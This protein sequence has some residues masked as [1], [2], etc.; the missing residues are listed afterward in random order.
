MDYEVEGDLHYLELSIGRF[1]SMYIFNS[2]RTHLLINITLP[3]TG[4]H[5]YQKENSKE[6]FFLCMF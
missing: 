5:Y 3:S 2:K 1:F 6:N 4:F